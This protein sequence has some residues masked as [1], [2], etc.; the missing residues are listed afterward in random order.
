MASWTFLLDRLLALLRRAHTKPV[1]PARRGVRVH[2]TAIVSVKAEI[3]EGTVVGPHA[4]IDEHVR[5]GPGC[6]I[7]PNV[8][9]LRYTTI[10]ARCRIHAGA[11]LGDLPQDWSFKGGR[12][13]VRI[14]DD[15]VIREGVTIH[16][17]TGDE[18]ETVVGNRCLLMANSHVGHNGRVG[19]GAMLAN[20]ALVAG[21]AQVGERAV[22]SGNCLIHQFTRVGRLAMMAGGSAVQM[23]VPP[24][25]MTQSLSA[26]TVQN[27]NIIGMRRAGFSRED[28]AAVKE[29]FDL[30]FRSGLSVKRA[31][32]EL[33]KGEPHE[34][35][36][37][38]CE[39]IKESKRGICK[40]YRDS[41]RTRRDRGGET[42]EDRDEGPEA[43]R[44]RPAA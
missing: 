3:G 39:F 35:V 41:R 36:R 22:I 12:S 30:F 27:L 8:V 19:D 44:I 43:F 40:F 37:E 9:I 4:F 42:S 33:E 38:F 16:R 24:F 7:G 32:E 5:I 14:G 2:P 10:G 21:Y 17:G 31:I 23:D 6:Q 13:Y 15:C 18:T 11:V 25:C 28:R 26:N 1:A 34:L 20:G 29:A